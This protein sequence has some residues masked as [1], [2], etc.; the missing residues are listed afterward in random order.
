M[1]VYKDIFLRDHLEWFNIKQL[2]IYVPNIF[3]I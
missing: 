1:Q 2:T 3:H